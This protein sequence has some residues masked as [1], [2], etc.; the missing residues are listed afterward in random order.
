MSGC[1]LFYLCAYGKFYIG[2]K[3]WRRRFADNP[4]LFVHLPDAVK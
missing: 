3:V 4:F 1:G 2:S